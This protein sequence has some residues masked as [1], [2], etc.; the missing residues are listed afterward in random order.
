VPLVFAGELVDGEPEPDR[1][2]THAV[3]WFTE[4]EI[5]ALEMHPA[6]REMLA[7]SLRAS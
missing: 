7:L 3:G 1:L 5:A 2:E 4:Q 6:T